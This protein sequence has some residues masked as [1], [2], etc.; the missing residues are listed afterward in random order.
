[1]SANTVI[2]VVMPCLNEEETIGNCINKAFLSIEENGLPGEVIVADNGSTDR[3][4]QIA[5]SFGAKVIHVTQKGYG[6]ALRGGI[7]AAHGKWIIMGDSDDSYDFSLLSPFI[8]KL[9]QGYDLVMGCRM[10]YGGGKIMPGAM[11][12]KHRW[13]GNPILSFIGRVFFDCP[14][15]DFHCGLRA[16][17]K[18]AY[19]KMNLKMTG[20][21]FASELVVKATMSNMR[22]TEV[23][24]TLRKDGRS[25][26]PHLRSWRDGWRHLRFMLLFS[27]KWLFFWPGVFLL[28]AGLLLFFPLTTG[29]IKIGDIQFDT[30]TLLVSS[31]MIA[32][33]FQ[34]TFFGIFVRWYGFIHGILPESTNLSKLMRFFS[35]ES[36]LMAGVLMAATG[37][38]FLLWAVLKWKGAG[39]GP[40]SY[41]DSLRLVIPAVTLMTLGIQTIFSSFLISVLD[42][43]I[44]EKTG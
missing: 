8:D 4:I 38:L 41:P 25:R 6:N 27:P 34:V 40:M 31:F 30:N 18:E 11:P 44:N 36:G 17:T 15:T 13:I 9:Q 35:L 26:P 43:K 3:S 32:T 22:I 29:P 24:I 1:M 39:F 2:S 28:A 33:G 20:M 42:L 37:F 10:P 7:D 21:E 23:P 16:F 12:W 19:Q 5:E 14:I